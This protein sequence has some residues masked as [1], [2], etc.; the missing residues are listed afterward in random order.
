MARHT[1]NG[2]RG[3]GLKKQTS[4]KS[5][6]DRIL[7]VASRLFSE[8]GY[9]ATSLQEIAGEVGLHKTSLFHYFK[10]KEEI[11]MGVMDESLR[12]HMS[13]LDEVANDPH[14]SGEE[15]LKLAL[16]KQVEVTCRYKNHINVY[17]SEIKSLSPEHRVKYN[18]TRKQYE[19]YFEKIITEV[20]ANSH[21]DLL[22]GL[23]PKIVKLGILG[24]CNWII[25][26]YHESGSLT[27]KEIYEVFCG[28][29]IGTSPKDSN[30]T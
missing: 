27:P 13:I 24:M 11:L 7:A 25:K 22:K 15:K 21:S 14:L 6:S 19:R 3:G 9:K 1:G 10:G 30:K 23:D 29:I 8:K 17:L 28:I 20:Q 4:N 18:K 5:K 12:D 16:E 26:W 2:K